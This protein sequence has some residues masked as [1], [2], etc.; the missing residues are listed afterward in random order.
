MFGIG[1]STL[2]ITEVDGAEANAITNPTLVST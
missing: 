2:G 1:L